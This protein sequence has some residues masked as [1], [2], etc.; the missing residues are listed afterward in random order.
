MWAAF[1]VDLGSCQ[2]QQNEKEL[3]PLGNRIENF[4][5]RNCLLT[6]SSVSDFETLLDTAHFPDK[7]VAASS[8][9]SN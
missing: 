5:V 9:K 1:G 4:R 7:Q 8:S 2:Q 6:D 3:L